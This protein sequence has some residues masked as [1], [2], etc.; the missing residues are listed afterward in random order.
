VKGLLVGAKGWMLFFADGEI[1]PILQAAPDL[2]RG[3]TL[4][5]VTR[6]YPEHRIAPVEDGTLLEEASPPDNYV[7]AGHFRG[8]SVV[9]T[10]DA[11]LDRPSQLHR[12][13]LDE[14]A[15]QVVYL[16]AMHSVVTWFAYGIW[17]RNG[18]LQRALSLSLAA[19]II[20][21]LGAPMDFEAPFWA[22]AYSVKTQAG[23]YPL[24]FHPLELG[25]EALRTFFGFNYEGL[26]RHDDPDLEN[27]VL[28]GFTVHPIH[29]L[30]LHAVI[31]H[32]GVNRQRCYGQ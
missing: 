30:W 3:A 29:G 24:P 20:E 8:L 27:I 22:G 26:C 14:A 23:S 7:Y 15:G 2:D 25:E 4:E 5:L 1:R 16:H 18:R 19:G 9:C 6:L 32:S 21:N 13:F 28:A 17:D 10:S 12:R 11:A 31:V